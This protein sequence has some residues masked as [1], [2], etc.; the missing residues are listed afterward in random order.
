[1]N[2]NYNQQT[3]PLDTAVAC[4]VL[5]E[6][7][8]NKLGAGEQLG[9]TLFSFQRKGRGMNTGYLAQ[10]KPANEALKSLWALA[11]LSARKFMP[12]AII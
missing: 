12:V 8:M 11:R 3:N 9:S 2:C 6:C 7:T 4:A 10:K 1:M 5:P